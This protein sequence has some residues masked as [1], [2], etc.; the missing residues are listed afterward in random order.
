MAQPTLIKFIRDGVKS[1]YPKPEPC[2]ICDSSDNPEFH[3][4][5][6]IFFLVEEFKKEYGEIVNKEDF[7][8][9]FI[10]KYYNYLVNE[11]VY[12]CEQHHTL[13]HKIYGSRPALFTAQKQKDWIIKQNKKL[14]GELPASSFG[15]YKI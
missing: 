10:S 11:T 14:K 4:Y 8:E 3:H 9:K 15:K 12:L 6:T 5:F 13:L 2:A 7:R 1:N